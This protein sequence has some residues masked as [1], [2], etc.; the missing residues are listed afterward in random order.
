MHGVCLWAVRVLT[1]LPEPEVAKSGTHPTGG[2]GRRGGE[3]GVGWWKKQWSC[4]CARVFCVDVKGI[5][6]SPSCTRVHPFWLFINRAF[7]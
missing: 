4:A 3:G 1:G 2:E 5:G 6:E 7:F